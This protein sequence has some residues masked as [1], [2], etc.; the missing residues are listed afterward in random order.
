MKIEFQ[1]TLDQ[2]RALAEYARVQGVPLD[3]FVKR[4]VLKTI[5]PNAEEG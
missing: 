4:L 3:E 1:V 5:E 2:W